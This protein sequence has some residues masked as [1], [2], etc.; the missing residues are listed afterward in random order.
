M[1]VRALFN[2]LLNIDRHDHLSR[3][4]V[5]A[6]DFPLGKEMFPLHI[7][8]LNKLKKKINIYMSDLSNKDISSCKIIRL[9]NNPWKIYKGTKI[10]L[11][12]TVF[13]S[14]YAR[15]YSKS[16]LFFTHIEMLPSLIKTIKIS[17]YEM[18]SER[19]KGIQNNILRITVT[20]KD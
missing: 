13:L 11:V 17:K 4:P 8:K 20:V 6:F 7:L 12:T 18:L 15:L 2:C 19:P 16:G 9:N 5:P 14:S 3:K 10:R 1:L